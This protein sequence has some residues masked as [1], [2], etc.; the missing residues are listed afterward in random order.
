[1]RTRRPSFHGIWL[2]ALIAQV[3]CGQKQETPTTPTPP[4]PP[5]Q[6]IKTDREAPPLPSKGMPRDELVGVKPDLVV[7]AEDLSREWTKDRKAANAKYRKKVMQIKGVVSHMGKH[8]EGPYIHLKGP[9]ELS[10]GVTCFTFMQYPWSKAVDG[11]RIVLKGIWDEEDIIGPYLRKCSIVELGPSPAISISAPDLAKA[12]NDLGR[13][14]FEGSYQTK[15]LIIDGEIASKD[16]PNQLGV[17]S[18]H[19]TGAGKTRVFVVFHETEKDVIGRYKVGQRIR[20]TGRFWS[21]V[22][23]TPHITSCHVIEQE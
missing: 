22:N 15:T 19:L 6:A 18:V 3:G 4:I 11:Q 20:A 9:D 14:S 17:T 7:T 2:I 1:M 12:F 8:F 16:E 23:G 13:D 5:A 10:A 21:A